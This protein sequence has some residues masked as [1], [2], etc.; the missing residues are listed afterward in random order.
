MSLN[1]EQKIYVQICALFALYIQLNR[2]M[3]HTYLHR[4]TE[5][6]LLE[7]GDELQN[8]GDNFCVSCLGWRWHGGKNCFYA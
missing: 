1:L 3:M 4:T 2:K 8:T 5:S 7:M 6:K